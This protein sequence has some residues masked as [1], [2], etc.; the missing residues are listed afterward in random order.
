MDIL[1]KVIE[2]VMD[3]LE[4]ITFVGS[5]FI[6]VYLFIL[7]P[8]QVKGASM[9]TTFADGQYILTSKISYRISSPARGDVI[10]FKSPRDPDYDFIKRIIGLPGD[11]VKVQN[12]KV[13]LNGSSLEETY[14]QKP[15]NT[16]Q[17]GFLSEGEEVTVPQGSL[18]VLGDNRPRSSDSREFGFI[19]QGSIVG[20]VI[21]RYYPV[22]VFGPIGNPWTD[23]P[24]SLSYLNNYFVLNNPELR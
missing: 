17:N 2:F 6:V 3:I 12:S 18:F 15:T 22:D 24:K 16:Y 8:H 21:F 13:Y 5:I 4:T 7:Q 23:K 10:V 20:R 19:P 11:K 14:A 1:K 9:D